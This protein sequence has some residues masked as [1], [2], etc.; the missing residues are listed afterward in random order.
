MNDKFLLSREIKNFI[1][2]LDDILVNFPR[3]DVFIKKKIYEDSI[4]LLKLVYDANNITDL[5]LKTKYKK[6]CLTLVSMID[7]YIEYCYKKKYISL[8]ICNSLT[9]DLTKINKM[10]YGWSKND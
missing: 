2:Y 6:E 5:D 4:S 3:K 8:K 7:F 9:N 10:I 1:V